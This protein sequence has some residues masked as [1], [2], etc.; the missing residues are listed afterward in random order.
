MFCFDALVVHT[1]VSFGT[2]RS[3]TTSNVKSP[4]FW[5]RH[6]SAP[7]ILVR[8]IRRIA[9]MLTIGDNAS[10]FVYE[11]LTTRGQ[12][13]WMLQVPHTCVSFPRDACGAGYLLPF[14]ADTLQ[15]SVDIAGC[16]I[17]CPRIITL[18]AIPAATVAAVGAT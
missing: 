14:F 4:I 15:R 16:A 12:C 18:A 17:M 6:F 7:T 8:T 5:V 11:A 1:F 2:A 13:A 3:L 10:I 9:S